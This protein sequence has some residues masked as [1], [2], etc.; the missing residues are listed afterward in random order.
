MCTVRAQSNFS[1]IFLFEQFSFAFSGLPDGP[2]LPRMPAIAESIANGAVF[3]LSIEGFV[4]S[5]VNAFVFVRFFV[6]AKYGQSRKIPL[7]SQYV[8]RATR[9]SNPRGGVDS[10]G[11]FSPLWSGDC[12][13]DIR[14]AFLTS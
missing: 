11:A 6:R 5:D 3:C 8:K 14:T 2:D 4:L 1:L 9:I 13:L 10:Y 7:Y 12:L